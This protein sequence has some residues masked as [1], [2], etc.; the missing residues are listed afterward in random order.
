M[1]RDVSSAR[2]GV[3]RRGDAQPREFPL[4]TDHALGPLLTAASLQRAPP[5]HGDFQA[6]VG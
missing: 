2:K 6:G 5:A 1:L 3:L 4:W